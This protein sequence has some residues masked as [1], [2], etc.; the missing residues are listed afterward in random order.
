MD[1][2]FR[3][4][5]IS[6]SLAYGTMR[7]GILGINPRLPATRNKA[8][9]ALKPTE[10][11]KSKSPRRSQNH[12]IL[13]KM[14]YKI[15]HSSMIEGKGQGAFATQ[16]IPQGTIIMSEYPL[17][18]SKDSSFPRGSYNALDK[19]S[20]EKFNK[21]YDDCDGGKRDS[22]APGIFHTNK[23]FIS[24]DESAVFEDISRINHSCKPNT[25]WS[26]VEDTGRME[27][28]ALRHIKCGEE[29]HHS[30]I[31]LDDYKSVDARR[32][33]LVSWEFFCRCERCLL[34][35]W[36]AR[37]RGEVNWIPEGHM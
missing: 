9:L 2:F 16:D 27:V 11:R 17:L 5:N 22:T 23:F 26:W 8:H 15:Q 14:Y 4:Q 32:Q 25:E 1:L 12:D 34:E 6:L 10:E 35:A 30:Y 7:S 3:F 36:Q 33:R 18:K 28:V 29:L 19:K 21:L 20:L 24:G 37:Y 31:I 13:Q